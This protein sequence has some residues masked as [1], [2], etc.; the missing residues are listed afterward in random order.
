[1]TQDWGLEF[2]EPTPSLKVWSWFH[3]NYI[4]LVELV[5]DY[6]STDMILSAAFRHMNNIITQ[7]EVNI[8]IVHDFCELFVVDD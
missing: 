3:E 2:I 5:Q 8:A 7:L 6:A 1:M 4:P